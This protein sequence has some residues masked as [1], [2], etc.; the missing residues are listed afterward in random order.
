[1]ITFLCSESFAQISVGAQGSYLSIGSESITSP[2]LGIR[3]EYGISEKAAFTGSVNYYFGITE[4]LSFNATGSS[5]Q[6]SVPVTHDLSFL[7]L[8]L[9]AKYYVAGSYDSEFGLYG[10]FGLGYMI[11]PSKLTYSDFDRTEYSLDNE[12]GD[13]NL[14]NFTINLG[15]G[16]E[17]SFDTFAIFAEGRVA[18]PANEQ[19]GV[20]IEFDIPAST[21]L[22]L[23]VR[24]PIGQ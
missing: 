9:G 5:D 15:V 13:E 10:M 4:N 17:K 3:G 20:A 14:S 8:S 22:Q 23:G 19:N 2:G 1:M 6:I 16:V 12:L 7:H 21:S 18:L 24:V 11:A